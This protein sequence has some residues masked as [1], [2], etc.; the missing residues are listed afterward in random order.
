MYWR[1]ILSITL[2]RCNSSVLAKKIVKIVCSNDS[3]DDSYKHQVAVLYSFSS[4]TT[5]VV[6]LELL[7]L[8]VA[9]LY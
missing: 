1:Q 3:V 8:Y 5:M 9:F 2:Q 7:V 6:Y 4:T